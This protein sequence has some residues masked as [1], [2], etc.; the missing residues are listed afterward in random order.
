MEPALRLL[1]DGAPRRQIVG[2]P[3]PRT[4][5]AHKPPQAVEQFAQRVLALRGGLVHERHVR[6]TERPLIGADITGIT[7]AWNWHPNRFP[8]MPQRCQRKILSPPA[9]LSTSA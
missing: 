7:L 5:G 1:L 2:H 3:P 6:H 8:E 9:P 4:A